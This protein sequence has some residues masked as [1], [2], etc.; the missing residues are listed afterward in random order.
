MGKNFINNIFIKD[1]IALK[2][3]AENR[4]RTR[5]ENIAWPSEAMANL[6]PVNVGECGRAMFYKVIGAQATD[7][8]SVRGRYI[9]DA[10]IMYEK[11]HIERFKALGMF[12]DEQVKIEYETETINKVVVTGRMDVVIKDN[13]VK[14]GIEIKSVSAFKAPDI[15]GTAGKMPLPAANNLM[16]AMLYRYWTKYIPEGK[17]QNID[18]IYLMYINRSDGA[19]FY[20]KV[21]LDDEGYPL[22]TAYDQQGNEIYDI[23]LQNHKSYEQLLSGSGVAD[24]EEG[25]LAELRISIRDIFNKFDTVY[26]HTKKKTL[27]PADYKMLF[28][29]E[30]LE[31]EFKLGRITKRKLTMVKKGTSSYSDYKCSICSFQK[32]CLSDSGINFK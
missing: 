19:I 13:E 30:D 9:C 23:R 26:T 32:K 3:E 16:Q 12:V 7:E 18:D 6:G 8:M 29:P 22:L 15:F 20:Y 5:L 14:K 10:G 11:Y 17:A 24:K 28:S 1:V 25:R 31:R 21:D 4:A 27:P 2:E